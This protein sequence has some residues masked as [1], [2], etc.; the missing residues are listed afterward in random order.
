MLCAVFVIAAAAFVFY[1]Y[2]P[3]GQEELTLD[4]EV[5]ESAALPVVSSQ[6]GDERINILHGYTA[7]V[8]EALMEDTVMPVGEDGSLSLTV[9]CYDSTVESAEWRLTAREGGDP[10]AEKPVEDLSQNH[11]TASFSLDL[12]PYLTVGK[13]YRLTIILHLSDGTQASYYTR[14]RT[15]ENL[16]AKEMLNFVLKLHTAI[17]DK[18]AA[19]EY[20]AYLENDGTSDEGTLSDVS[21]HSTLDQ[22]SW[23]DLEPEEVGELSCSILEIDGTFASFRLEYEIQAED[24]EG[25]TDH[26]LVTEALTVQWSSTRFYLM[27]YHRTM[28][29]LFDVDPERRKDGILD[30]GIVDSGD[31]ETLWSEDGGV[32]VFDVAGELWSFCPEEK[33]LVQIFTFR[34]DDDGIR[35][36]YRRYGIRILSAEETGDTVF[37]VYGYMNRGEHEGQIGVS[38]LQYLAEEN[39]LNELF[40]VPYA[41]TCETLR[42]G[43]ETLACMGEQGEVYLLMG[44]TLYSIDREG[45]EVV[46]LADHA[47]QRNL[48][49]NEEQTAAAWET[50]TDESCVQILYL[51]TGEMRQ[52]KAGTGE[53]ICPEGFIG[54]DCILGMGYVGDTAVSGAREVNPYYAV[55]IRERNGEEAVRY[56]YRDIYI[57]SVTVGGGQVVL[58]RMQKDASGEFTAISGDTLIQSTP[59]ESGLRTQ[60][61]SHTEDR[62]KRTWYL[63]LEADTEGIS[64]STPEL[65]SYDL[66]D[67]LPLTAVAE[68][69]TN[70]RCYGF[71]EG[72]L[73][74]VSD[75][76]GSA[77]AAVYDA[78]GTVIDSDGRLVWYRTARGDSVELTVPEPEAVDA[79]EALR[80]CLRQILRLS[81][82]NTNALD[83]LDTGL[84]SAEILE[85]FF[86]G[87]TVDLSGCEVKALLYYVDRGCPVLIQDR[88]GTVLLLVGFDPFNILTYD[89]LL[90]ETGKTGLQ[91]AAD[92]FETGE[93]SFTGYLPED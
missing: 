65:I 54:E 80:S 53:R 5:W 88:S 31:V 73:V 77:I 17:F 7:E 44:D 21:I 72:R 71:A 69:D 14:V 81:N 46:A 30:F 52:L 47:S 32:L 33:R 15:G 36:G 12:S 62:K 48:A 78:M 24:A 18:D 3:P 64:C 13:D 41:G 59:E 4:Y 70:L 57:S 23:G 10:L 51:D 9:N 91:D 75:R 20:T 92:L 38:C 37:L 1:N 50:E 49:V 45:S 55:V 83:S 19:Q 16:H 40:F 66:S 25:N 34:D 42:E 93:Y 76:A 58:E 87:R 35:S 27:N 74:T 79:S 67:A 68:S 82:L 63:A 60:L 8:D 26:F 2:F 90:G 86:P 43:I 56:E 22:F 11:D 85:H 89:P 39:C 28:T 84:S 29:E 61:E 6:I